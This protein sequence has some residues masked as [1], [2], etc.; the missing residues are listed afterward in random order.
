MMH[1]LNFLTRFYTSKMLHKKT[2]IALS[3]LLFLFFSCK[4]SDADSSPP[5]HKNGVIRYTQPQLQL[6]NADFELGQIGW[7]QMAL[8]I[9]GNSIES[10]TAEAIN[11]TRS[12]KINFNNAQTFRAAEFRLVSPWLTLAGGGKFTFSAYIKS[13]KPEQN[14]SLRI[15]NGFS[16]KASKQG[17]QSRKRFAKDFDTSNSWTQITFTGSLPAAA[18]NAYR[19]AFELEP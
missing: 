7:K 4:S 15:I 9:V 14:I 6:A 3:C 2:S 1:L 11:G 5:S 19:L 13:D 16:K 18:K 10:D 12:L 17:K 8:F